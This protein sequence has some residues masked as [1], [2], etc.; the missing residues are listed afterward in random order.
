MK[1]C[2]NVIVSLKMYVLADFMSTEQ[3]ALCDC[4]YENENISISYIYIDS[5]RRSKSKNGSRSAPRSRP[6]ILVKS[7]GCPAMQSTVR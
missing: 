2:I 6:Q 7:G 5:E 1:R 4:S 3:L